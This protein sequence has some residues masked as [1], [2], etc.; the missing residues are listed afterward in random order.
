MVDRHAHLL[1]FLLFSLLHL[2]LSPPTYGRFN[3]YSLYSPSLYTDHLNVFFLV[4]IFGTDFHGSWVDIWHGLY[5]TEFL[6]SS[7]ACLIDGNSGSCQ[8]RIIN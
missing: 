3:A 5:S 6:Y 7:V 1:I 2:D 4:M 8:K